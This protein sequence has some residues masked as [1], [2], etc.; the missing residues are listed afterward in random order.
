M[1]RTGEIQLGAITPA[2]RREPEAGGPVGRRSRS[3]SHRA[4]QGGAAP[5]AGVEMRPDHGE[6]ENVERLRIVERLAF[7]MRE[8]VT[9]GC[10]PG[11]FVYLLAGERRPLPVPDA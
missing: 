4:D 7:M 9:P 5:A 2:G 8:A 10:P 11:V 3:A 1:S 6:D